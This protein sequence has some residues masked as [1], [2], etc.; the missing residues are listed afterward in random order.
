MGR[1]LPSLLIIQNVYGNYFIRLYD[2][3]I[4]NSSIGGVTD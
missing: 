3:N 1:G 2:A 4:S